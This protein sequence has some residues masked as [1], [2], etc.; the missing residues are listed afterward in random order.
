MERGGG[1]RRAG[2]GQE[3]LRVMHTGHEKRQERSVHARG[4]SATRRGA[5]WT[6]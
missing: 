4:D 3:H 6:R 1:G 2:A 5:R